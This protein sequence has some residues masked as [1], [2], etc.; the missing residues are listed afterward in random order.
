MRAER[1]VDLVLGRRRQISGEG[2]VSAAAVAVAESAQSVRRGRAVPGEAARLATRRRLRSLVQRAC[3]VP[4]RCS[5]AFE[6]FWAA[7]SPLAG[8]LPGACA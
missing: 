4:S 3:K 6:I 7:G 5:S 2:D 8:V 1:R